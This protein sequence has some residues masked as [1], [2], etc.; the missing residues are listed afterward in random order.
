MRNL[1]S[2]AL[3]LFAAVYTNAQTPLFIP[4]TLA[5][6]NINLNI[7]DSSHQFFPG[8]NTTTIGYNGSYLGP[9][10]ILSKGQSLTMNV[11]NELA[12]TTTTHWHGLHVAPMNDGG[13]HTMI[14]PS[15]TWS[16]SFTVMDNAAT[17]WYHPHMHGKTMDQVMMGA[18]GLIIVRDSLEASLSLPRKYGVDDFPLVFQWQHLDSTTKQIILDDEA[19]NITMVNGQIT[20]PFVN[21]PA[22]IVRLRILNA[23]SHRFFE[24]GFDD[25][26]TF[27]QI[28]SDAG[29]LNAP[30]PLTRLML[31]SGE[32]AEILVDF[33][34]QQ[35]N[36]FFIKQ[37]G[38]QLPAGY[39]GGPPD[40]MGMMVLGPLD[41]TDFNLLQLNVIAPTSDPVTTIPATL[42]L[43]VP[44]SVVGADNFT[45]AF[46]GVPMMSMTNFAMNGVQFDENVINMTTTQNTIMKWTLSNQSMMP[47]PFHIHGNHFFVL[48]VN[49]ATPPLNMQGRKDVAVVSPMGGSLVLITQYNDFNDP[50]MPYMFHCHILS[51]EDNGMMGQFIVNPPTSSVAENELNN[52]SR[53]FP[54]P[55][56]ENLN[57]FLSSENSTIHQITIRN[58]IGQTIFQTK[59]SENNLTIPA[60]DFG[61]GLYFIEV[62]DEKGNVTTKKFFKL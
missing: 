6:T 9:T 34:G 43:N 62:I 39:P 10:I 59:S 3:L 46:T 60:V 7:A 19:D 57:L 4:D 61:A 44:Y 56:V 42:S 40:A 36:T 48:A 24:F 15:D 14:M 45:V 38:S 49:G 26:R 18:A 25:N 28:T 27:N 1:I 30:V 16:P 22:Q 54:N 12:D 53:I 55:V 37:Y 31:G 23:S 17:Y 8:I 13:P 35:G 51:H 29:L 47:H 32:R 41:N 50:M 21:V 5:G 20:A 33:S 11:H 52:D 2:F 58:E